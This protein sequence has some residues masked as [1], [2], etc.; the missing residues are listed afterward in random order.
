MTPMTPRLQDRDHPLHSFSERDHRTRM[1]HEG[2]GHEP[3]LTELLSLAFSA[4]VFSAVSSDRPQF[5][6]LT[7]GDICSRTRV[8]GSIENCVP[9]GDP[10]C[11][12]Y[13]PGG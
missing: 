9:N 7:A 8:S 6:L 3:P 4:K 13:Q 2:R 10:I 5:R 1:D 12:A 11:L